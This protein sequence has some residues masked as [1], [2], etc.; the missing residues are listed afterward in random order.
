MTCKAECVNPA[1]ITRVWPLVAELVQKSVDTCGDCDVK[2]FE[3][4]LHD[5]SMLLW[6]ATDGQEIKAIVI[7]ELTQSPKLGR[8]CRMRLGAGHDMADWFSL[9]DDIEAYARE[10]KCLRVRI[11]GRAGWAKMFSDYRQPYVILE[12]ILD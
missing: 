9:K 10:E 6:L 8:V 7:T 11:E 5:G 12:K 3:D 2:E 1:F 4:G